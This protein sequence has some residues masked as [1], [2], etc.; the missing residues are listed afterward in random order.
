MPRQDQ[1]TDFHPHLRPT[2][3]FGN[4][5]VNKAGHQHQHSKL[6]TIDKVLTIDAEHISLPATDIQDFISDADYGHQNK[7]EKQKKSASWST[8]D[9]VNK[10]D[11]KTNDEI[12]FEDNDPILK[13][14]DQDHPIEKVLDLSVERSMEPKA[15]S[16]E[17]FLGPG[18]DLE[19][20]P[21]GGIRSKSL[22]H[23]SEEEASLTKMLASLAQKYEEMSDDDSSFTS[24]D[25]PLPNDNAAADGCTS[26]N[27]GTSSDKNKHVGPDD[28]TTSNHSYRSNART[29]IKSFD[30]SSKSQDDLIKW[31]R[32]M[33]LKRC[34]CRTMVKTLQS[35]KKV[36][37]ALLEDLFMMDEE[38]HDQY[39]SFSNKRRCISMGL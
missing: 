8:A 31:D 2:S 36:R 14:L 37:D 15:L 5:E 20:V 26:M 27:S 21:I 32:K 24:I 25:S 16:G 11:D 12:L 7:E 17:N 28:Q 23:L 33:G 6:R 13:L 29:L 19:P 34:H 4:I 39:E 3:N 10:K 1:M 18:C 30:K 38:Q 22:A 9:K 35:R